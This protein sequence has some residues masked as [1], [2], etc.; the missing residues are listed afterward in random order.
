MKNVGPIVKLEKWLNE[1][2][3]FEG[4]FKTGVVDV[5]K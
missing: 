2:K 1:D 5:F 4:E 3:D